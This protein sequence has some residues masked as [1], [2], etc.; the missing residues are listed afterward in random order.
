MTPND[1]NVKTKT[2]DAAA[3]IAGRSSG[4]VISRNARHGDAPSVA[5][6]ASRSAGQVLPHRADGAHD[7]GQVEHDVG[8]EDR[9]HA[10]LPAGRQEGEDGGA[11]HDGRQHERR[12][13]QRR[14]Q[15][16]PGEAVAGEHV[17]RAEPDD[18]RQRRC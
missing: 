10:A 9:R 15:P 13:E 6:A 16:P 11:H 4:S 8:D 14:Q 1:V 17:R 2:I 12:G 7:D 5:A 18:D 3:R